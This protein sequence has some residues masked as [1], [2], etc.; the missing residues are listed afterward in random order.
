MTVGNVFGKKSVLTSFLNSA[1]RDNNE[2]PTLLSRTIEADELKIQNA[3]ELLGD[4]EATPNEARIFLNV[5][6]G[7]VITGKNGDDSEITLKNKSGTT[8]FRLPVNTG[9]LE[10]TPSGRVS[11]GGTVANVLPLAQLGL[12]GDNGGLQLPTFTTAGRDALINAH[13]WYNNSWTKRVKLTIQQTQVDADLTDFPVY[14]DLSTMP[15]GFWSAVKSDGSDIVCTSS[16]ALTKLSR[17]LVSIDTV[18]QTGELWVKIPTVSGTVDTTFYIYYGNAGAAETNDTATWKSDFKA[19]WHMKD[20]TTS[21]V[22]DST[23]NGNTATKVGA[24]E[25][26]EATGK[27]GKGQTFDG[28]NDRMTAPN[29]VGSLEPTFQGNFAVGMWVKT[30]TTASTKGLWRKNSSAGGKGHNLVYFNYPSTGKCKFY[31][32]S[33]GDA[34]ALDSVASNLNNGSWRRIW[35]IRDGTT[36]YMYIDGAEDGNKTIGSGNS[37][38]GGFEFAHVNNAANLEVSMDEVFILAANPGT[39]W[40]DAEYTNQNTPTTFYSVGTEESVPTDGL[41]DLTECYGLLIYNQSTDKL[42]FWDGTT[43]RVITST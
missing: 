28:S 1:R 3:I 34:D 27:V 31:A 8:V 13:R 25:P 4:T 43:W 35:F 15:A 18:G 5:I 41:A 12:F 6:D 11:I 30:T 7:F 10:L 29:T 38:E 42:N 23:T 39:A 24:N 22:S 9:N 17:E 26:I 36:Q 37:A 2:I 19:I 40:I 16:D 20:A 21:T 14:V 33:G 32:G